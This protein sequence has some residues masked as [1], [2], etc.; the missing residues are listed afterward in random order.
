MVHADAQVHD[1]PERLR[2]QR[3]HAEHGAHPQVDLVLEE[4]AVADDGR[5]V[6]LPPHHFVQF[7]GLQRLVVLNVAGEVVL[8]LPKAWKKATLSLEST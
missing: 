3:P 7:K 2:R 4:D 6:L 1:V 5:E 8:V